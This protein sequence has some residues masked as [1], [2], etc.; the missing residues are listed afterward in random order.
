VL[1][2]DVVGAARQVVVN[3]EKTW[4]WCTSNDCVRPTF[5]EPAAVTPTTTK[6][7]AMP[8]AAPLPSPVPTAVAAK[9]PVH[10]IF[11]GFAA[12]AP[13]K[14]EEEAV[15]KA[16]RGV[17]R[18]LGVTVVGMTDSSGSPAL[19]EQLAQR[20]AQAIRA[21]LVTHGFAADRISVQIDTTGAT[22]P[23]AQSSRGGKDATGNGRFRRVD[24]SF[25][26]ASGTAAKTAAVARSGLDSAQAKPSA[27]L[28]EC[29]R[30]KTTFKVA[31]GIR[32]KMHL[33][34]FEVGVGPGGRQ[35][36]RATMVQS[37][38]LPAFDAA[39]AAAVERCMAEQVARSVTVPT[40][41]TVE[42]DLFS[43]AL[44]NAVAV[45]RAEPVK[46]RPRTENRSN[47]ATP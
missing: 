25:S 28:Q 6:S 19:N 26:T 5:K 38:G 21:M 45:Q 42:L 46:A 2:F 34:R 33:A 27:A 36:A 10:S 44:K 37:S 43:L 39:V 23:P 30:D 35:T 47:S 32:P 13:E 29:V 41:L 40:T 15:V 4:L 7:S 14:S 31:A 22:E 8:L 1:H 20:R 3:G 9:V 16:L 11:F 12:A 18:S 24:I 17:D